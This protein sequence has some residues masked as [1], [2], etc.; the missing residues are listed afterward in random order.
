MNDIALAVIG[1]TGVYRLPGVTWRDRMDAD[2]RYGPPSGPVRIA[3]IGG[4]AVA[5]LARHGEG[6]GVPP[7]QVNYRAN[8]QVLHDLGARRVLAVNTVGGITRRPS[9][10]FCS[11][12]Q[13][14]VRT[15]AALASSSQACR[16][17]DWRSLM[18]PVYSA[19]PAMSG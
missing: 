2:T 12:P 1:G 14:T 16:R 5:F 10:A 19:L 17:E 4:H 6:H 11:G 7:H 15:P 13:A 18:M 3:D 9:V 8:L